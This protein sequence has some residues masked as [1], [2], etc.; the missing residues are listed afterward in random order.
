V[1]KI[2]VVGAGPAGATLAYLL[3]HRGIDVTLL[4]RQ[5]DF[6]REFR[7]EF[8]MPSG[9]LALEE[10]GLKDAMAGV[11][12]RVQESISLY[13]NGN[14]VFTQEL[15]ADALEQSPFQAIS[16]PELLEMLVS[17]AGKSPRFRFERG[18]SVKE[19]LFE[20]ERVV[21]VRARTEAGEE[22][23]HADLVV[24]ADGRASI[25]RKKGG[26]T[27]RHVSPPLDVVWWKIP[28]PD[29]WTGPS[30]FMGRGHFMLVYKNWE[31]KLQIAWII[32][33]G[34]FRQLKNRSLHEWT[35]EMANQVSPEFACHL[36]ACEDELEKPF[37]LDAVSDCVESWS[38]PGALLIGDAAHTMSPVGGQGINI[39]LRDTI[40]AA[41]H[42]VPALL[43][44]DTAILDAALRAIENE[45]VPEVN[46]IQRLQALPPKI[47]FSSSWWSELVR[48]LL[49]R[50][51]ARPG[52][53]LKIA[54]RLSAMP[55][56]VTDV[57]LEV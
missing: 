26:F 13:L 17:E 3:A 51:V 18:A 41:N 56:G 45:R 32:V 11:S 35:E 46:H 43:S 22:R 10:M 47:G 50:I 34:S 57:H 2:L 44:E 54:S 33:K 28:C 1:P 48:Q 25:V 9:Y 55:F 7:G 39:A 49:A 5:S 14:H 37:V 23:L 6:S 12:R 40:V 4:E 31:G 19:L 24:G 21:G 52:V 42:L 30:I 27:D 53:R 38:I 36:R 29:D 8:L 20:G 15:E 16:Q